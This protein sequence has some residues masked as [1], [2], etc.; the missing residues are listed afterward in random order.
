MNNDRLELNPLKNAGHLTEEILSR[1]QEEILKGHPKDAKG[2]SDAFDI[3]SSGK[4]GFIPKYLI[5]FC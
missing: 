1:V 2:K 4:S 3:F 5:A